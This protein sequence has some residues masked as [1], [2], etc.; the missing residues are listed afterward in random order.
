[1]WGK[2]KYRLYKWRK[3]RLNK[4]NYIDQSAKVVSTANILSSELHGRV[5]VDHASTL[6]GCTLSGNV[7]IGK[8]TSLWGPNIS[9]LALVHPIRIGN[10]CSIARD[11]TIQEYFHDHSRL[12]TYFIGRNFFGEPIEN[13][14]ISKGPIVI[15]SDVWIGTGVQ[16]MSG[17]SIGHGAVIGANAVVTKDVPPY[18]IVG[19]NPA[20]IIKYRFD[21]ARIV[22]LLDMKWWE[23]DD[24][25]I[26]GNKEL[27]VKNTDQIETN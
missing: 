19:G 24:A 17:V 1:M 12:T 27:F 2:I 20:Q 6:Y 18:A 8:R 10:F 21:D 14:V 5:T 16:I 23:W 9:V 13:E 4:R 26:Q 15:G 25:K 11:V 22:E 7:T 3:N